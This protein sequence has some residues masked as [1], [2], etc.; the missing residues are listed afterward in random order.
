MGYNVEL[1]ACREPQ[2]ISDIGMIEVSQS[3]W[4]RRNGEYQLTFC[5][6]SEKAST[7]NNKA[8]TASHGEV[9]VA[10]KQSM[11]ALAHVI[12]KI[13]GET[14]LASKVPWISEH[15]LSRDR[16]REK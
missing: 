12:L 11:L 16:M 14:K 5:P 15:N 9:G 8:G 7:D 10:D 13:C 4:G 3:P 2:R 6:W 1:K